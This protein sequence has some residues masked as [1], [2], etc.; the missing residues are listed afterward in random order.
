MPKQESSS[1]CMQCSLA[2]TT[3]LPA[4]VFKAHSTLTTTCG[5]ASSSGQAWATYPP[6]TTPYKQAEGRIITIYPSIPR[7]SL[8]QVCSSLG[9]HPPPP[10]SRILPR[11]HAGSGD[12]S[13]LLGV[14]QSCLEQ[15]LPRFCCAAAA[16]REAVSTAVSTA[17]GCPS[18]D[19]PGIWRGAAV[20]P[21]Q[22]QS[23]LC[24][25]GIPAASNLP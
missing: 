3:A 4:Q 22:P 10:H 23:Q 13:C 8:P 2:A 20:P 18:A 9:P 11:T 5:S 6:R 12:V 21:R 24:A 15:T 1:T 17:Q 19:P 16:A 14:Q 25:C 7:T